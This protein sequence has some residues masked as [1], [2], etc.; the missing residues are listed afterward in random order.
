MCIRDRSG[1]RGWDPGEP[2]GGVQIATIIALWGLV[3]SAVYMLRAYRRI[4]HG[5]EVPFTATAADLN[6]SERGPAILLAFTLVAVGLFPNLLLKLIENP[7]DRAAMEQ[8]TIAASISAASPA[9]P[10]TESPT[11][12]NQ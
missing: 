7:E 1:F 8:R 10:G 12:D 9:S 2:L 6:Q 5:T 3:I 4:F 11:T